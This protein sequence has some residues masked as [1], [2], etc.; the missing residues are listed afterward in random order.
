MEFDLGQLFQQAQ[1]LQAEAHK[2]QEELALREVTGQAGAG[3]V[4]A[5]ANGRGELLRLGF[6]PR[7][8]LKDPALLADLVVAAVNDALARARELQQ[9]ELSKLTGGLPLSGPF[10]GFGGT[11]P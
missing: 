6:D 7:A 4:T 1:K 10:G 5:V 9:Q 3:M 11:G 8:D 2:R